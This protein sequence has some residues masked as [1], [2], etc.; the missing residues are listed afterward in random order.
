[1]AMRKRYNLVDAVSRHTFQVKSKN[2]HMID[3][4]DFQAQDKIGLVRLK[5]KTIDQEIKAIV[6]F[7]HKKII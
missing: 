4:F 5:P 2:Q 6:L 1:M 7:V 3:T